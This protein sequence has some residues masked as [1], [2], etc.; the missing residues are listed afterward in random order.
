MRVGMKVAIDFHIYEEYFVILHP[1][2]TGYFKRAAMLA[3]IILFVAGCHTPHS[4]GRVDLRLRARVDSYNKQSFM[5][6]YQDPQVSIRYAYDALHLLRDSLPAYHDGILRAYNNL[7]FGYYMLAEHDSSEAYIDSVALLASQPSGLSGIKAIRKNVEVEKV[8]SQLMQIRLLQRSCRIADSYQ[9]LYDINRSNVLRHNP[10]YYL[11]SYAQMEYYITS[12]TLN[13]HYRNRAVASSSGTALSSGTKKAMGDLLDEV[14]EARSRLRCDYAEE[15]SLNYALAHSYY[16]L[17]AAN[18]SDSLLLGKAYDYLADNAKILAIPGQY[19]IYHLA[20]VF[21]LQAFIVADTNILPDT[22]T[23]HP[24][25]R[26]KVFYLHSLT[27]RLYPTDALFTAPEYGLSMFQVSTHLFFQTSDPYQHLG[28]IVAA[29]EYC[30]H[31]DE[32]QQAYDYYTMALDDTSWHDGMAPKFESMLYDGLIRMGYSDNPEENSHWYAREMELLKLIGQNES[33]D[34]MLQ[35]LLFKSETRN[36]YYILTIV[37]SSVFL[38]LLAVLVVLLRHRSIVLR[39]EKQA[40]QDAKRK[41]IERIA[42]VETCLSVMRHDINPFLSYLTNKS[43]SPEMR[44]EILDQLLRTFSNI[45]NWTN[46]SIPSGLQF[47]PTVFPL[48]EVFESVAASCVR[49]EHDVD[50]VFNPTVLSL[51]GDRQ[52]VEIMLRNLVNNALQHTHKGK[53]AVSAGVYAGDS[54]FVDIEVADTGTGMDE[55]TLD[56]LFRADKEVR[57]AKDP[58]APHGTGFGLILCKYIIK[59]HDD[60]TLRGCR[61]WAESQPGQGSTFH[62]LLAAPNDNR[63]PQQAR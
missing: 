28:A 18:G 22:Y 48:G 7:S 15:L 50:L 54:R 40:L 9:L 52:L 24:H 13:Y 47:Q 38:V 16:R 19:S 34:L 31:I 55:E 49:L 32:Y 62:C 44:Q 61:I 51:Y 59:R 58:S 60:N 30:L 3:V 14:E 42:N 56:N 25:C 5:N 29:A 45:K 39:N 46:L 57:T 37:I 12:L 33:A 41:D 35:D 2:M 4:G 23:R 6:R 27:D 11:Y 36:H 1:I 63:Q 53:V 26:N 43:L 17:A 10:E 21:Q 8:I 20:N